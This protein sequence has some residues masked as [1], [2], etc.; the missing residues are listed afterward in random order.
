MRRHRGGDRVCRGDGG[1]VIVLGKDT[2]RRAFARV[3]LSRQVFPRGAS[4]T[5]PPTAG[6]GAIRI[7][8]AMPSAARPSKLPSPG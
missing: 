1:D 8:G 2:I 3:V 6:N 7:L 4:R 5:P